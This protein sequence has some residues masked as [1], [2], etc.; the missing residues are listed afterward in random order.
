MNHESSYRDSRS[1]WYQ[2]ESPSTL[3]PSSKEQQLPPPKLQWLRSFRQSLEFPNQLIQLGF[4]TKILSSLCSMD[5]VQ[6]LH[7]LTCHRLFFHLDLSSAFLWRV[8]PNLSHKIQP[9]RWRN[10]TL[11]Q[12]HACL[13]PDLMST[14]F[15]P[16]EE[17]QND[18]FFVRIFLESRGISALGF[19]QTP[20][21]VKGML[22][23]KSLPST[24]A[25]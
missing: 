20:C 22:K 16:N 13:E 15:G 2:N 1:Q 10:D 4:S 6:L 14:M 8:W 17:K 19:L 23:T 7:A 12:G 9:P 25:S 21:R 18:A 3:L 11:Q 5:L 24:C